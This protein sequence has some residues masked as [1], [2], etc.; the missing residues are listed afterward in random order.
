MKSPSGSYGE[1]MRVVWNLCDGANCFPSAMPRKT[2]MTTTKIQ[3]RERCRRCHL[4]RSSNKDGVA[5]NLMSF[6][7]SNEF[8]WSAVWVQSPPRGKKACRR[9][10][11]HAPMCCGRRASDEIVSTVRR[12]RPRIQCLCS[13]NIG[14]L[15]PADS[16]ALALRN[17]LSCYVIDNLKT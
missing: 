2:K 1:S 14:Y 9:A 16:L 7:M 10:Q 15:G 11:L 8:A 5:I 6:V 13:S 4:C 3:A 12:I 17:V